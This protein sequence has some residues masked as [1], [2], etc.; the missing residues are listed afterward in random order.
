MHNR[1]HMQI[2]E[3]VLR[4]WWLNRVIWSMCVKGLIYLFTRVE[5]YRLKEVMIGLAS[6]TNFVQFCYMS[7]GHYDQ[8]PRL[9][10]IE[11]NAAIRFVSRL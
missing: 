1:A 8:R 11:E 9:Y 7:R 4:V 3:A 10:N 2:S 6:T 5:M